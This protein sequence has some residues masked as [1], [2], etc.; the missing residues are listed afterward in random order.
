MFYR[1]WDVRLG[2]HHNW[3][4]D[5]IVVK[6]VLHTLA[7]HFNCSA[8]GVFLRSALS[9][10]ST[11]TAVAEN[12]RM[13]PK[14]KAS[15]LAKRLPHG[16]AAG[17][18]GFSMFKWLGTKRLAPAC[19]ATHRLNSASAAS[20]GTQQCTSATNM[21]SLRQQHPAGM[22][23][24]AYKTG[25]TQ[26]KQLCWHGPSLLCSGVHQRVLPKGGKNS[27]NADPDSLRGHPAVQQCEQVVARGRN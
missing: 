20:C 21:T 7:T 3:S 17:L 24:L 1:W 9:Y 10:S 23:I 15:V 16:K 27:A 2:A 13:R 26:N 18:L 11:D 14:R 12:R 4:P 8:S 25:K 22:L 6:Q 19:C 5:G